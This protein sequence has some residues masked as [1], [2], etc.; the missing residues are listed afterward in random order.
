VRRALTDRASTQSLGDAAR[1]RILDAVEYRW[2]HAAAET[3]RILL[4]L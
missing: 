3:E 1:R 4:S 2:D